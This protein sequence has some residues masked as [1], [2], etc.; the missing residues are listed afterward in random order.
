MLE[1]EEEFVVRK[2]RRSPRR[3]R[4]HSMSQ[5]VIGRRGLRTIATPAFSDV[6]VRLV[7]EKMGASWHLLGLRLNFSPE[8]LDAIQTSSNISGTDVTSKREIKE[9]LGVET[10]QVTDCV[11]SLWGGNNTSRRLCYLT[12]GWK[13]VKSTTV[14]PHYG[15]ENTSS[16]RLC[17]LTIGWKHVKSTTVLPHYGVET[18]QVDDCVAS[19]WFGNTSSR[20]LRCLTMGETGQVNDCVASLWCGNTS[21]RQ[22][23]CLTMVWK[24]VDS[25]TVLPHYG[26]ETPQVN[27]CMALIMLRAWSQL[28]TATVGRLATVLWEMGEHAIALQLNP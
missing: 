3:T 20:R 27:D 1:V 9:G 21:S 8:T 12:V 15:V 6:D 2:A 13:H 14:L 26:V 4:P 5:A 18:R 25:A 19:L 10:R 24:H 28:P 16:R 17:C 23:C 7:A 22:L 11:A